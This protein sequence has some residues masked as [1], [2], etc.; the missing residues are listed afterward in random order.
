M[1]SSVKCG[2]VN[3]FRSLI[4]NG[5]NGALLFITNWATR[6]LWQTNDKPVNIVYPITFALMAALLQNHPLFKDLNEAPVAIAFFEANGKARYLEAGQR[7]MPAGH[8]VEHMTLVLDGNIEGY[9]PQEGG[10]EQFTAEWPAG[11]VLGLLPFSRLKVSN[12][13]LRAAGPTHLW[14]LPKEHLP[15]LIRD[16][17]ELTQ[18]LVERMTARVREHTTQS[19]QDSKMGA[20][21][22]MAAGLTHDL[23]NPAAAISRIAAQWQQ[24]MQQLAGHWQQLASATPPGQAAAV[25]AALAT[26]PTASPKKLTPMQR[27]DA[28]DDLAEH[29]TRCIGAQEALTLAPTLAEAG[30]NASITEEWLGATPAEVHLP[31]LCWLMSQQQM[32]TASVSLG[33]AA[34]RISHLV[35]QMK[36]F[37]HMDQAA[38]L[39]PADLHPGLESTAELLQPRFRDKKVGLNLNLPADLPEAQAYPGDLNQ[40]WT[41]LLE[42]A[43]D[44]CATGGQVEVRATADGGWVRVEV[45]DN[46]HGITPEVQARMFEPFYTTKAVGQGSGLGLDVVKTIIRRHQGRVEMHSQPGKTVFEVWLRKA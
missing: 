28:E 2:E 18:R 6:C 15:A 14:Q 1:S 33:N 16:L 38:D 46:G 20:L 3:S 32:Q 7:L 39:Q 35:L 12:V 17:P 19:V 40:V 25:L 45:E 21:G 26:P 5:F 8:P 23:N 9:A 31:L 11:E 27:A 24:Q 37:S 4:C 13:E 43:L 22:R 10:G 44:A 42:N 30:F 36:T 41:N 34:A 29:L